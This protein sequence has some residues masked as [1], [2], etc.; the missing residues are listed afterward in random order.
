MKEETLKRG[1]FDS[2][3]ES[4][5]CLTFKDGLDSDV[6]P[7]NLSESEFEIDDSEFG[8]FSKD[9][10]FG[11]ALDEIAG[12]EREIVK[13]LM[14]Q[15]QH[16]CRTYCKNGKSL[17]KEELITL[18]EIYDTG[19]IEERKKAGEIMILSVARYVYFYAKKAF[20]TWLAAY[21]YDTIMA[22]LSGI[23]ENLDKFDPKKGLLTTFC[24]RYVHHAIQ[25]NNNTENGVS[26]HYVAQ[27]KKMSDFH[28][29][30]SSKNREMT[31]DEISIITGNSVKSMTTAAKIALRSQKG[32]YISDSEKDE[33]AAGINPIAQQPTPE[34]AYIVREGNDYIR[35][36]IDQHL[37]REERLVILYK[38]G[39][40]HIPP[41]ENKKQKKINFDKNIAP[42]IE[43]TQFKMPSDM[44]VAEVTGIPYQ[45]IKSLKGAA[46]NKLEPYLLSGQYYDVPKKK[47]TRHEIGIELLK[48]EREFQEEF[49][50]LDFDTIFEDSEG[51]FF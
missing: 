9:M 47:A 49:D 40:L 19:S 15:A 41:K 32:Q 22:G 21:P 11:Y 3:F 34:D 39:F 37:T 28:S 45:H 2:L 10:N 50:M 44:E 38:F 31:I 27:I 20:P 36:I 8:D 30:N 17:S 4:D 16:V 42:D 23:L 51:M 25:R 1:D 18:K 24:Q 5:I 12:S 13:T 26:D 43:E 6:S 14:R 48:T 35:D 29:R 46:L 33:D 7:E